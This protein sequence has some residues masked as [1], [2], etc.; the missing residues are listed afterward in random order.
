MHAC[1]Y[2]CAQAYVR[3]YVWHLVVDVKHL[4]QLFSFE[5]LLLLHL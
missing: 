5:K 2:L 1:V 3:A 4:P